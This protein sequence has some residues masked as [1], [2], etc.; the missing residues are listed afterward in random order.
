MP[1]I[2]AI[3]GPA[4]SGKGTIARALAAHF[5]FHHLD[6]G[7][8]YRATGAKGGDPVL[9]A[10]TLTASDLTRPG[11]RSAQAGQ[12]ASRIAA[13]P[14]VRAALVDFQRRF[15]GQEPGAVLDGRDIGTV[16]CPDAAVKLYV[17]ASDRTRA[18]RRAA[19]LGADADTMLKEL[20]ERDR[21]DRE[22]ATAPL[23][24]ASDAVI[25]DTTDLTISDAIAVA[26]A[27]VNRVLT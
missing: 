27:Q 14:A 10:Q 21:R 16:I 2:I 12:A 25:L 13:I 5:G 1:L 8:L 7:L 23:R 4:A 11:L 15:A 26:I 24:P 3:D 22:R 19:E 6:T 18:A 17:T 9:A 20:R